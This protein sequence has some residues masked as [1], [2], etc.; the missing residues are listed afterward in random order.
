MD[1]FLIGFTSVECGLILL[2]FVIMLC[3]FE[4]LTK[5]IHDFILTKTFFFFFAQY[6]Y[7]KIF[8]NTKFNFAVLKDFN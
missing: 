3:I 5:D 6:S 8:A 7:Y 1:F 4:D 2:Y